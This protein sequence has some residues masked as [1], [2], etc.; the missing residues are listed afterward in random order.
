M[1]AMPA[2]AGSASPAGAGPASAAPASAAPILSIDALEVRYELDGAVI[3]AVRGVSLQVAAGECLGIVGESG[4]GKSQMALASLGLLARNA[5]IEGS[6]RFEGREL[7]GLP[8]STLNRIRGSKLS[9]VFQ[10]PMSSL[11]PH[12]RI[13]V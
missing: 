12:V 9:M 4:S 10:D 6:V 7:L 3:G 8:P 5:R 13:G 11:T 1:S 2:A